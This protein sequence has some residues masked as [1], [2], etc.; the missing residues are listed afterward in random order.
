MKLEHAESLVVMMSSA[1]VNTEG[2]VQSALWRA[3]KYLKNLTSPF[4]D[5][6]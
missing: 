3:L 2:Y 1:G 5:I 4:C 6:L